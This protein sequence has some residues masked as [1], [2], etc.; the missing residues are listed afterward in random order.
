MICRSVVRSPSGTVRGCCVP[1]LHRSERITRDNRLGTVRFCRRL[2]TKATDKEQGSGTVLVLGGIG[3]VV[4]VLLGAV[5]LL[6]A[7]NASHHARAAAD[8]AAL[9]GAM[10]LVDPSDP[11]EPCAVAAEFARQ[12]QAILDRCATSADGVTVE[13]RVSS[14][15]SAIGPARARARAGPIQ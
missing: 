8:M 3:V 11:R 9:A 10:T 6:A 13:V 1:G 5:A 2:R 12:N 14:G 7:V 15:W 4:A